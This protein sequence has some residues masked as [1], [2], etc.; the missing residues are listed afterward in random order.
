M[1]RIMKKNFTL[2]FIII[3][4]FPLQAYC[5]RFFVCDRKEINECIKVLE[6]KKWKIKNIKYE[7]I[8]DYATDVIIIYE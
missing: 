3:S 7:K 4:I 5:D 2:A 6:E 1:V 8:N